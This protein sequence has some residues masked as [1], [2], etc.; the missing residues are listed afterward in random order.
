MSEGI[1]TTGQQAQPTGTPPQV[2]AP[3]QPATV[4][5][6]N[7]EARFKGQQARMQQTAQELAAARAL[8]EQQTATAV[9]FEQ[10]LEQVRQ[11]QQ[12]LA[13]QY[14]AQTAQFQAAQA[15]LGFNRLLQSEFPN[16]VPMASVIQ[17]SADPDQQ[18]QILAAADQVL[19]SQA[20]QF[21]RTLINT[22]FA[23]AT[24]A[25]AP[26]PGQQGGVGLKTKEDLLTAMNNV[27]VRSEEYRRLKALWEQHPE[28]KP[29]ARHA[30]YVKE[31]ESDWDDS[32]RGGDDL[33]IPPDHSIGSIWARG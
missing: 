2:V 1:E 11:Q 26:Q 21:A 8:A 16:L 7:W 19:K 27:P 22:Q 9:A 12:Q 4:P 33:S 5:A 24:P 28:H 10:Q 30:A 17:R 20:E 29:S 32:V 13:T 3:V 14:E 15:E 23:G 18:R 6:E 31:A 25:A